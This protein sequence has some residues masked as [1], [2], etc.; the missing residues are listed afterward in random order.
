MHPSMEKSAPGAGRTVDFEHWFLM[1]A[2]YTVIA[3][4]TCASLRL[5]VGAYPHLCFWHVDR[6]TASIPVLQ[7]HLWWDS[8]HTCTL[9]IYGVT[10]STPVL[11]TFMVGQ[12]PHLCFAH[13]WCDSVH[14]CALHIYGVTASTPVLCTFMV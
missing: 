11:C 9:H 3:Y 4:H 14:T 6:R 12:R 5:I 1:F 7:A 2:S 10:A 8:V 13:L